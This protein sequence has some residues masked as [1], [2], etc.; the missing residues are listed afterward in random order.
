MEKSTH[1]SANVNDITVV[2]HSNESGSTSNGKNITTQHSSVSLSSAPD[3][4]DERLDNRIANKLAQPSSSQDV[5]GHSQVFRLTAP[6]TQRSKQSSGGYFISKGIP[7][8]KAAQPPPQ[9]SSI[10]KVLILPKQKDTKPW[11]SRSIH[12]QQNQPALLVPLNANSLQQTAQVCSQVVVQPTFQH[13]LS[14]PCQ[15]SCQSSESI[16]VN[17]NFSQANLIMRPVSATTFQSTSLCRENLS[18]ISGSKDI[19]KAPMVLSNSDQTDVSVQSNSVEIVERNNQ[20]LLNENATKYLQH[21]SGSI[22]KIRDVPQTFDSE[23][24]KGTN[25]LLPENTESE[26]DQS[27]I[28]ISNKDGC[29]KTS[30]QYFR[31]IRQSVAK[32]H[33]KDNFDNS[34]IPSSFHNISNTAVHVGTAVNEKSISNTPVNIHSEPE[35]YTNSSKGSLSVQHQPS[36][37]DDDEPVSDGKITEVASC[38]D[39]QKRKTPL[40]PKRN[41]KPKLLFSPS[42]NDLVEQSNGFDEGQSKTAMA[43]KRKT[44]KEDYFNALH[45]TIAKKAK[46][47]NHDHEYQL[48]RE[49]SELSVKAN[50]HLTSCQTNQSSMQNSDYKMKQNMLINSNSKSTQNVHSHHLLKKIDPNDPERKK[51]LAVFTNKYF[52]QNFKA[53]PYKLSLVSVPSNVPNI[54]SICSTEQSTLLCEGQE[55]DSRSPGYYLNENSQ[56]QTIN[57][58]PPVIQENITKLFPKKT[59]GVDERENKLSAEQEHLKQGALPE[60]SVQEDNKYNASTANVHTGSQMDSISDRAEPAK[61]PSVVLH[62]LSGVTPDKTVNLSK[63]FQKAPFDVPSS[64]DK[65]ISQIKTAD[66]NASTD[67]T[68]PENLIKEQNTVSFYKSKT[69]CDLFVKHS[70]E[71]VGTE[72]S[73]DLN[74]TQKD[75][76][77]HKFLFSDD[78]RVKDNN[79]NTKSYSQDKDDKQTEVTDLAGL[80]DNLNNTQNIESD[81]NKTQRSDLSDKGAITNQCGY[82]SIQSAQPMPAFFNNKGRLVPGPMP[83]TPETYK[84]LLSKGSAGNSLLLRPNA[85]QS[86]R[87]NSSGITE[88][89]KANA[90]ALQTFRIVSAASEIKDPTGILTVVDRCPVSDIKHN[91][92]NSKGKTVA[93]LLAEKRNQQVKEG[94]SVMKSSAETTNV[95]GSLNSK[96]NKVPNIKVRYDNNKTKSSEDKTISKDEHNYTSKPASESYEKGSHYPGKSSYKNSV[97][98]FSGYKPDQD[99]LKRSTESVSLECRYAEKDLRPISPSVAPRKISSDI[100]ESPG[101]RDGNTT[102]TSMTSPCIPLKIL[103]PSPQKPGIGSFSPAIKLPITVQKVTDIPSQNCSGVTLTNNDSKVPDESQK[104]TTCKNMVPNQTQ[105][106]FAVRVGDKMYIIRPAVPVQPEKNIPEPSQPKTTLP[107]PKLVKTNKNSKKGKSPSRNDKRNKAQTNT[108]HQKDVKKKLKK[109]IKKDK[110]PLDQ[111]IQS[112]GLEHNKRKA[113]KRQNIPAHKITYSS[114]PSPVQSTLDI[115]ETEVPIKQEPVTPDLTNATEIVRNE[116]TPDIIKLKHNSKVV[117]K[118]ATILQLFKAANHSSKFYMHVA[119][120]NFTTGTNTSYHRWFPH[121]DYPC[122]LHLRNTDTIYQIDVE[123]LRSGFYLISEMDENILTANLNG[124]ATVNAVLSL[125]PPDINILPEESLSIAVGKISDYDESEQPLPN[126][127]DTNSI[128]QNVDIIIKSIL[129]HDTFKDIEHIEDHRYGSEKDACMSPKYHSSRFYTQE[130]F[131]CFT[132]HRNSDLKSYLA[133]KANDSG[134]NLN[135]VSSNAKLEEICDL[136]VSISSK[137]H[138]LKLKQFKLYEKCSQLKEQFQTGPGLLLAADVARGIDSHDEFDTD[139]SQDDEPLASVTESEFNIPEPRSMLVQEE[140]N[141][142]KRGR[143]KKEVEK[144][145]DAVA[146]SNTNAKAGKREIK[147]IGDSNCEP[148]Q[149]RRL[150][151]SQSSSFK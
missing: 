149:I 45:R 100:V 37:L 143:K 73:E 118:K 40:K 18:C 101:I 126:G 51:S 15:I 8:T 85:V 69:D 131:E 34:K 109:M 25:A 61:S 50:G 41:R 58:K 65:V 35:V 76:V 93:E 12:S 144:L 56:Q 72:V 78:N 147:M 47:Q 27:L 124:T 136:D 10:G 44:N 57:D 67:E 75:G 66:E 86:V 138:E 130:L 114:T 59:D 112:L 80:K 3:D 128:N 53:A 150:T 117:S 104:G 26:A 22:N 107:A 4:N 2:P 6:I 132:Q 33:S 64:S 133:P 83:I 63:L 103:I 95:C 31:D 24:D 71:K 119:K 141:K 30:P 140:V 68:M 88:Q 94:K 139:T 28:G 127:D 89:C 134:T 135:A 121:S 125:Y 113:K 97:S 151:R 9:N 82:V 23:M 16:P 13:S 46:I 84:Y 108:T 87:E 148:P 111:L 129:K 146:D 32:L 7:S 29:L 5:E 115:L 70:I 137:A 17:N 20:D 54:S 105:Q 19:S 60:C 123:C 142:K 48:Q 77:L 62:R 102:K 39:S 11:Q 99:N 116:N 49:T 90:S 79:H 36:T 91:I 120:L 98:N 52:A 74:Q 42:G 96:D 38:N 145:A 21:T 1:E 14:L 110:S 106:S 92:L 122:T 43:R 55:C 81:L